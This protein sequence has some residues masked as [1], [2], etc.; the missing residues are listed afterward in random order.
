VIVSNYLLNEIQQ[1]ARRMII[2]HKGKKIVESSTAELFDPAETLVE[3][4]SPD[5][6]I[7]AKAKPSKW[8][9]R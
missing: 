2:I 4:Q 5:T 9:G 1:V 8:K 3:V 7:V 6:K